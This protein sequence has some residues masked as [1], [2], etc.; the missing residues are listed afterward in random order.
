MVCQNLPRANQQDNG[1]DQN[2][3]RFTKNS[4]GMN[5]IYWEDIGGCN[6]DEM[7]EHQKLF[8]VNKKNQKIF[9][10]SVREKMFKSLF[11]SFLKHP[12]FF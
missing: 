12:Y 8:K 10:L 2:P 1:Y 11:F 4:H 7:K 9:S 6:V 5:P 3:S